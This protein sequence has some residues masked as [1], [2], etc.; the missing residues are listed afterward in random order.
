M[1]YL[2]SLAVFIGV[3]MLSG[4]LGSASPASAQ[5]QD[6]RSAA[7]AL[8][9]EGAQLY[10][11]GDFQGALDRFKQAYQQFPSPKLFFNLGQAFRGLSRNPEALEAFER[12]L[13]E[14]KDASPNYRKQATA[15]VAEL[16]AKLTR[17]AVACN[18]PGAVV[19]IDR[20][21]QGTIP[22]EKPVAVEP[23]AHQLTLAWEGETKS[24]EFTAVAGQF[25]SLVLTFEEKKLPPEAVVAAP[26]PE[27]QVLLPAETKQV[28][29]AT[30]SSH[31]HTW[32][33]IAGGVVVAAAA[34]ALILVYGTRD[35][36]PTADLGTQAI[37]S[38]Q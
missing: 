6:A 28:P 16:G 9:Q 5:S 22:L 34:A 37:G 19:T 13:A 36:Y 4:A 27:A 21:K 26:K 20:N 38:G 8:A 17:V 35:H 18:R 32:Y 33:W 10:G 14:A 7:H 3:L 11:K 30:P 2:V 25:L 29:S 15:Q 23:G 31:R 24:V 1:R 12:F